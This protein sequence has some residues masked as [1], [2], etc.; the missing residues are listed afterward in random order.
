MAFRLLVA[1]CSLA[2]SLWLFPGAQDGIVPPVV[3]AHYDAKADSPVPDWITFL[4]QERV[5]E[6]WID[7]IRDSIIT[8]FSKSTF[9]WA[10]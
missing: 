1:R 2:I 7:A 4:K 9:G 8:D 6:S 3:T 5:P 10:R